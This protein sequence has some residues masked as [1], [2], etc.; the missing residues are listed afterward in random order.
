MLDKKDFDVKVTN[1]KS[2]LTEMLSNKKELDSML[3]SQEEMSNQQM[4]DFLDQNYAAQH[5]VFAK[6]K[7]GSPSPKFVNY[8]NFSGGKTSLDDL[9]GKYVYIDVWATWCT[10]CLNEIPA[11]QALE[12]EF[13]GK[14]I[15]FLSI[16][17]DNVDGQRGSKDE[18]KKMLTEKKLGGIQ[19]YADKDFQSEFMVAYNV[20]SIPRFII[21][22]PN[23]NIVD[24]DAPRP[25]DPKLK[26]LFNTFK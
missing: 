8:E 7:K 18:W 11:L 24:F 16:S 21:I 14:N 22:D 5:E 10:P 1:L 15:Q 17:V 2:K 13:Q 25:S 4:F 23:G 12:K 19:L 20:N 26:E 3:V 9:K 6:F